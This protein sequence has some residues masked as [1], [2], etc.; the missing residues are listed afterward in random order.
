MSTVPGSLFRRILF[1]IHL[2]CG[3]CA[4][5]VI[6]L[7]SA[8]GVLLAYEHQLI[9]SAARS[10]YS[11]A[12]PGTPRLTADA[13]A[14]RARAQAASGGRL[15]L[16]FDADPRAPVAVSAGRDD[17]ALLDP[18]TGAALADATTGRRAFF[19]KVERL[20]RWM[21]G[22]A[23]GAGATLIDA[24]NLLFLFLIAS[25]IYLWLPAVWRW[26]T[27]RGLVLLR[28][29]YV[30]GKVRDFSWH[31]V[32]SLWAFIPLFLIALSGVVM[33]YPWANRLVYAA[34][35]E[36]A[37][38]RTGPPAGEGGQRRR[39]SDPAPGGEAT[40]PGASLQQLLD[41]AMAQDAGWQRITLP[42]QLPGDHVD[43]T[44][45]LKSAA[46]RAPRRTLTLSTADAHVIAAPPAQAS[47]Q[48]PGQRTR[49]WL[50]FVHTGEQ[51]GLAGQTI[52][53]LAS[54]AA[55]FLAYSG[56]A[57]AWRR[58]ILPLYRRAPTRAA[59]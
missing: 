36:Q 26:R 6:L 45:E 13:L 49:S 59:G 3:V 40:A 34:Y 29:K 10:N 53:G 9:D 31:H 50:R 12:A 2:G 11:L 23:R 30:N 18:Y 21:G 42:L 5:L 39:G 51:Y 47:A 54:L 7:M 27:L 55:C 48:S 8:T 33:S 46:R 19:G 16:V 37:P 17:I 57:L 22:D 28:T 38:Q 35:G 4:G 43:V 24:A 41:T 44:L 25:G 14:A 58:L 15:S 52:A 32:F 56:L 20:H 1:W